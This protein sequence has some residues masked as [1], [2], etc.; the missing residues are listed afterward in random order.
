[1]TH[2][3]RD[4]SSLNF[5]IKDILRPPRELRDFIY[6]YVV[7]LERSFNLSTTTVPPNFG[8]SQISEELLEA[9][10]THNTCAITQS[11][12]ALFENDGVPPSNMWGAFPEYKQCLRKLEV[13]ALEAELEETAILKLEHE[14]KAT[15]P[16]VRREWAE[17]LDLPRLE[18]LTVNLHKR[19]VKRFYWAGFSPILYQLREN[20]PKLCI[21]FNISFGMLLE[22]AWNDD[23]WPEPDPDDPPVAYEDAG[24]VQANELIE[25]PSE[26]DRLY[27]DTYLSRTTDDAGQ[28][29]DAVK[30]LL[31][32]SVQGRRILARHYVVR[33][34][35]LLRV[36]MEEHYEVYKKV[37][38]EM[39][40]Y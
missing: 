14:C 39:S 27:V 29:R 3:T 31:S 32:E 8:T 10:Y 17:L 38:R 26:E 22:H 6:A 24:F 9:F 13:F 4:S 33:E 1:M 2:M 11:D 23:Q 18:S 37:K 35:S 19:S 21:M 16:E 20:L 15:R 36:C 7:P 34:P 30:G 40:G 28:G 12:L 25:P 5:L